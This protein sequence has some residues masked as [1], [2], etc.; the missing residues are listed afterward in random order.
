MADELIQSDA[1]RSLSK[2]ESDLL[3]FIMTRRDYPKTKYKNKKSQKMN[4]WEPLNGY[5]MTIPW[6]AIEEFFHRPGRMT[7]KAP[8]NSTIARAI[9]KLMS[10]GFLSVVHLGGNGKG[11]MSVYRLEHN[12]RVWKEGDGQCFT[13]AGLSHNKGFC[14][15]GSGTFCPVKNGLKN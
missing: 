2:S 1:Y 12:W 11:D 14:Q 13:K 8:N 15:P 5:G 4:Y 10:V 3:L 7:R 6:D 9:N